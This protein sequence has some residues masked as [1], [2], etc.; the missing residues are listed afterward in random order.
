[1]AERLVEKGVGETQQYIVRIPIRD[2]KGFLI[3]DRPEI[4]TYCPS[5]KPVTGPGYIPTP[6]SRRP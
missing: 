1:M 2:P 3:G 5:P 6:P 4:R